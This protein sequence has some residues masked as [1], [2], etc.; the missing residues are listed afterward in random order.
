VKETIERMLESAG[1]RKKLV[2]FGTTLTVIPAMVTAVVV[3]QQNRTIVGHATNGAQGLEEAKLQQLTGTLAAMCDTSRALLERN[4]QVD[5]RVAKA[6]LDGMGRVELEGGRQVSWK[7]KNQLTDTESAIS[8]PRMTVG[9]VWL[10]QVGDPGMAVPAV[11][12][13]RKLTEGASTIFQRMNPAGDMLRVATNVIGKNGKRAIG[14]FIPAVNADGGPNAVVSAAL[15]GKPYIGRAFVVDGW[16]ASAYQPL[17]GAGGNVIGMVF[18]GIP[19]SAAVDRLRQEFMAQKIGKTGYVYVMNASGRTRGHY[20]V[21]KGGA[22]D[23]ENIWDSRDA[24]GNYFIRQICARALTLGPKETAL[25]RYPWQNPDEPVPCMKLASLRYYKPWDWVIGASAPERELTETRD[26]IQAVASRSAWILALLFVLAGGGA[27]ASWWLVSRSLMRKID[28]VVE[29]L[30]EAASQVT[31]ASGQVSQNSE[32]LAQTASESSA[33]TEEVSAALVQMA[34]VTRRNEEHAARAKELAGKTH[35]S[36]VEGVEAVERMSAAMTSVRTSSEEVGKIVKTIDAIAFQTNLLALNAAVEAA[37]AGEAGLGFAVVADEVRRL[38]HRCADAAK[39]TGEKIDRSRQSGMEGVVQ[40]T[41]VAKGLVEILEHSQALDEL[42]SK[43]ANASHEQSVGIRQITQ[44]M[45]QID[46]AAQ[47]TAANAE[48]SASS[49]EQLSAEAHCLNDL[50]GRLSA[51][52]RG[53]RRTS[54]T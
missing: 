32:T 53:E 26:A 27:A 25:F 2:I 8:L 28:P 54:S 41:R 42:V 37:R 51:V 43:I 31:G 13:V 40:S 35:A 17:L 15:A 24:G 21:S 47:T 50:S 3:W 12:E 20:I 44:A 19:E 38:A 46:K 36:V 52:M 5:L 39:E 45:S 7:A 22:R 18:V 30:R 29:E 9:G 10:G 16:F 33:S 48:E 11:D 49:S 4:L 6:H 1:L 34:D 14:T 23:G